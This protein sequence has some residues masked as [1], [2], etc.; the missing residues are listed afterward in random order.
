VTRVA[1]GLK[2]PP[3]A[4]VAFRVGIVGHR[5]NRLPKSPTDLNLLRG[6]IRSVLESIQREVSEFANADRAKP[7]SLYDH[8]PPVLR[9]ISPLAEGTDR[10]FAEEA[11][12]LGYEL[13]CPMPF[14][15]SEFEKDFAPPH[16]LE[17]HSI[18]RFR[19]LLR[20]AREGA[21]G[22]VLFELDG[23]RS[24]AGAAY[25]MAG[26]VVLNQSDLLIAVWDG[27]EAA[28]AG[29]TVQT[30]REAIYYHVPVLWINPFRPEECK[31]LRTE[32][33][34]RRV[35]AASGQRSHRANGEAVSKLITEFHEIVVTE[36]GPPAP[37]AAEVQATKLDAS[38]YFRERKPSLNTWFIWK[39]FRDAVGD[40][41]FRLPKL[42]VPDFVKQID[43]DW[44]LASEADS[45]MP[46]KLPPPPEW[47]VNEKLRTHYAWADK[48]A[49][50]YADHYRSAYL[51]VYALSAA[52]VLAA[53]GGYGSLTEFILVGIIVLLV[54]FGS[55]RHWHE[56]WMEYRLLAELIRQIRILI[57]LGGG[58]PL[59]RTP[60]LS[61]YE[62][63]SQT[64]MYWHMRAIARATGIPPAKI[65]PA[66]LVNCLDYIARLV[67]VGGGGQLDFH[68]ISRKR[69]EAIE[70]FLHSAARD[71]FVL[72]FWFIAIHLLTH[73]AEYLHVPAELI[74]QMTLALA[75]LPAL[76]AAATMVIFRT[77][78]VFFVL[79]TLLGCA[80]LSQSFFST[81]VR[82][83]FFVLAALPAFGAALTGI[84]NQ[85]E[86][87]RLA[88]RSGAMAGAF[89]QLAI[90][91]KTLQH[92]LNEQPSGRTAELA[93]LIALAT[94]IT[95][96]MVDEVSDWRVLVAEQPMRLS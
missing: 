37:L 2:S 24:A 17:E 93:D 11:I 77:H 41:R 92:K 28:G 72:S 61:I 88:K 74:E 43:R 39:L 34:L 22:L 38:D 63:L 50:W 48:L 58:R 7:A 23:E 90:K 81:S 71:L 91:I 59:P 29:G 83:V 26:R 12:D 40:H 51:S 56:R 68:V 42:L 70:L 62:N 3:H 75:V 14:H 96:A 66:Y 80:A 36:L 10:I 85:G 53:V 76:G 69:S 4:K 47:W 73:L 57:P 67:G 27:G 84:A 44:P 52:A 19:E 64:W 18:D 33:D 94:E 25:G 30:L 15:Q 60:P 78:A 21:G 45:G 87:A 35:E 1:S 55:K 16:A 5:P 46:H 54:H 20:R 13:L 65:T 89:E 49:D 95:Q 31:I 86:F 32:H 6:V 9:A 8:D 82:D 79:A